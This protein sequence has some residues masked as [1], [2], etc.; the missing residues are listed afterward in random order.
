MDTSNFD[1]QTAKRIALMSGNPI[2]YVVDDNE[3]VCDALH[4]MITSIG[5]TA[6]TFTSAGEFLEGYKPGQPGC[7]LLDVRMPAMSGLDLQRE[8]AVRLIDLPIIMISGH[9]SIPLAVRAMKEGAYAFVEKPVRAQQVLNLVKQAVEQSKQSVTRHRREAEIQQRIARLT[10]REREVMDLIAAGHPNK[11]IA[12]LLGITE[13][14]VEAHRAK[15]M[16]K[17]E[18]KSLADLLKQTLYQPREAKA[19]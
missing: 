6:K 17:M 4:G 1:A 19:R 5:L 14:T 8:L 13:K 10:P 12:D 3:A 11:R 9:A 18:A 15:V 7:L 16:T 2:V